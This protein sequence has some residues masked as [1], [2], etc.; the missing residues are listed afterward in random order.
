MFRTFGATPYQLAV[1]KEQS[2]YLKTIMPR[3]YSLVQIRNKSQKNEMT[4]EQLRFWENGGS[5]D[6]DPH[7]L[8]GSIKRE[9]E[10][11][12]KEPT[13]GVSSVEEREMNEACDELTCKI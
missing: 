12:C 11:D 5:Y 2:E 8:E 13:E 1:T 3:K 7:T 6:F 4:V 9:Q 10:I